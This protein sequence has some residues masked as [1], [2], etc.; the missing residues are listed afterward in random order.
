[1]ARSLIFTVLL[2]AL[3]LLP[4]FGLR[5]S[6]VGTSLSVNT[7]WA[8]Y[9][10]AL[11]A[12]TGLAFAVQLWKRAGVKLPKLAAPKF[13]S[14]R[15]I[16]ASVVALAAVFPF[17]PFADRY[18]IDTTSLIMTYVL[19]GWGL[20][21][22][23]GR[24]GLL[25]LGYVAFYALGA[26]GYAL[27]SAGL[28]IGFWMALPLVMLIGVAASLIV[29]IPTLRLR[30]D[31]F[32]I[33][34][35]G[36]A[37]IVRIFLVNWQGL[38][39]GP[40]GMHVGRPGLFGLTFDRVQTEGQQSFFD[41]FHIGFDPE[42]RVIWLYYVGLLLVALLLVALR[43]LRRLPLGRAFEAVREDEI[44][45]A[46]VGINVARVKIAAYAISAAV[47]ALAGAFFAARQGF[48]SP[49]SFTFMET[50]VILAIVV[51]GGSG[52]SLGTVIAA[53]LL[54]GLPELFRD[55][56]DYRMLAFGVGMVTLMVW[57]PGG[58]FAVRKPTVKLSARLS[59]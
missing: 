37:E 18:T 35:L 51:L 21:V 42:L 17:L 50:A 22:T 48:I 5:L 12:V 25:D 58:L 49:E 7:D 6:D 46:A 36:F 16:G 59:A 28:G 52:S 2:A 30:G 38:T 32:A 56:Q 3:L 40:N 57:R 20:N 4:L 39:G 33:A 9:G 27:L 23:I 11:V 47:G 41:A 26:Y 10:A 13:L 55:L 54:I 43:W 29:G 34:T 8:D 24:T 31:Y 15:A 45:A 53:A 1:M 44:A 14:T 19:L